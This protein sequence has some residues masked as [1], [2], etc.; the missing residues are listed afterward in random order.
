MTAVFYKNFSAFA[1]CDGNP[2]DDFRCYQATLGFNLEEAEKHLITRLRQWR[3]GFQLSPGTMDNLLSLK[4]ISNGKH[5]DLICKVVDIYKVAENVWMLLLW[6]GTDA[7]PLSLHG[8]YARFLSS[9]WH[10]SLSPSSSVRLLSNSDNIVLEYERKYN[11]RI[12]RKHGRLPQWVDLSSHFLTGIDGEIVRFSTLIDVLRYAE[13][14]PKFFCVVRVVAMHT[15]Q[16]Q[17]FC[18][19][20]VSSEYRIRLTLEDSTARIH[21]LLAGEE[22]MRFF[23]AC[24]VD[25]R[26]TK[27][28]MLLGVPEQQ[29][30][31]NDDEF[32]RNPPWI[33]CCIQWKN[34]LFYVCS[35]WLVPN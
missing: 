7:P 24:P 32:T 15:F 35:T 2:S 18:S 16:A 9:M 21:A 6:D 29:N 5:F 12:V 10:G 1:L 14:D 25:Q 4:D 13:V 27:V 11:E 34:G 28:K 23:E 33:K 22:W 19:F 3:G 31:D 30:L 20:D 26:N 17:D 8:N